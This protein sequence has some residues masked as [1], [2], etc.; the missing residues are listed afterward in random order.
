V[1]ASS[2]LGGEPQAVITPDGKTIYALTCSWVTP[3]SDGAGRR[4]PR[5]AGGRNPDDSAITSNGKTVYVLAES[6]N[7]ATPINVRTGRGG[8]PIPVGVEPRNI[9]FTPD[10]RTGYVAN[11][12]SGTVTPINTGPAARSRWPASRTPSSP[13]PDLPRTPERPLAGVRGWLICAHL[14]AGIVCKPR[15]NIRR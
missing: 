2:W 12:G 11:Q 5:I 4:G 8:R 15:A 10:S 1:E 3:V 6:G 13:H 14:T 9:V 7:T